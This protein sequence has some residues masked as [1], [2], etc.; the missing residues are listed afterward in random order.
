M[1]FEQFYLETFEKLTFIAAEKA[2][3]SDLSVLFSNSKG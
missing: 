1:Y 2:I 3:F